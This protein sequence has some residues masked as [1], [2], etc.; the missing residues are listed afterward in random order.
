M[1]E[2]LGGEQLW[3]DFTYLSWTTDVVHLASIGDKATV[4][5]VPFI[6]EVQNTRI[7]FYPLP[8]SDSYAIVF[9]KCKL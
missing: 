2:S 3:F 5:E 6:V 8:V 7:S 1:T 9:M 4:S